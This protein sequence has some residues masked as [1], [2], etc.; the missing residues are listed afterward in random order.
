MTSKWFRHMTERTSPTYWTPWKTHFCIFF[1]KTSRVSYFM[2]SDLSISGGESICCDAERT[3]P[4]YSTYSETRRA[5]FSGKANCVALDDFESFWHLEV[6]LLD[7]TTNKIHRRFKAMKNSLH[8]ISKPR[9]SPW[10]DFDIIYLFIYL[11]F[12]SGDQ[13]TCSHSNR[14]S[15]YF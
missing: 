15:S 13:N 1:T 14:G 8:I 11:L 6:K 4:T 12:T 7:V 9:R 10:H 2:T 5:R 3:L